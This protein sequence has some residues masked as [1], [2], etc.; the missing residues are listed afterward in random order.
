MWDAIM[1]HTRGTTPWYTMIASSMMYA[2]QDGWI[3]LTN[4]I[5]SAGN[6]PEKHINGESRKI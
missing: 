2:I 6:A 4:G 5:N 1:V 3:A